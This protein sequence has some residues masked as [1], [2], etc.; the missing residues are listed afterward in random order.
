MLK[1]KNIITHSNVIN[2]ALQ[3]MRKFMHTHVASIRPKNQRK[4]AFLHRALSISQTKIISNLSHNHQNNPS[5]T[6]EIE[7][8]LS[9]HIQNSNL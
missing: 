2:Q 7:M 1:T 8:M 5:A 9:F 4:D 6:H 3:I